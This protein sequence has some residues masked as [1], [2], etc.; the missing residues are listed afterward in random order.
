MFIKRAKGRT[1]N[2]EKNVSL[3]RSGHVRSEVR[4]R[5]FR[6]FSATTMRHRQR[7]Q[8]ERGKNKIKREEIEYLNL[9]FEGNL[10][11]TCSW[12]S[13]HRLQLQQHLQAFPRPSSS[14]LFPLLL[15]SFLSALCSLPTP[16]LNNDSIIASH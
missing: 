16:S 8:R 10:L 13:Y 2:R 11:Q 9:K 7:T 4:R 5:A 1:E 15:L 14:S 6:S 3:L 12:V